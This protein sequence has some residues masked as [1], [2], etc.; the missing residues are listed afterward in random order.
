MAIK[1]V[2]GLVPVWYV[3]ASEKI[4]E[5]DDEGN[6]KE[7]IAPDATEFKL[8]PLNREQMDVVLE[9]ASQTEAGNLKLNSR[10]I[11][12]ALRYGLVDWKNFTDSQGREIKCTHPNFTKLPWGIGIE[13]AGEIVNQSFMSEEDSKNS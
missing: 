2:E 8:K 6:E 9:G 4:K 12:Y 13:L 1:A 7:V 11:G 10:G 3:P 5:A